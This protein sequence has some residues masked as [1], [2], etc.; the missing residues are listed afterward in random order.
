MLECLIPTWIL[1]ASW[2]LAEELLDLLSG[3]IEVGRWLRVS[4]AATAEEVRRELH[5]GGLLVG[6]NVEWLVLLRSLQHVLLLLT[7]HVL[8]L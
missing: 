7:E 1:L 4:A 5:L 6:R 8:A 3:R 2:I